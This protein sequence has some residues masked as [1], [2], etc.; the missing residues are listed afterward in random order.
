[1]LPDQKYSIAKKDW[2]SRKP[3]SVALI[4]KAQSFI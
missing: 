2:E 4:S 1:M 3:D